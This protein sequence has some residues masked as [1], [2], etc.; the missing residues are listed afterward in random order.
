MA[1]T[2][3]EFLASRYFLTVYPSLTGAKILPFNV[4]EV[5]TTLTRYYSL[6]SQNPLSK[7]QRLQSAKVKSLQYSETKIYFHIF[8][9]SF[10]ATLRLGLW[11]KSQRII[12][13]YVS[14]LRPMPFNSST[15][16]RLTLMLVYLSSSLISTTHN[17]YALYCT[18]MFFH[19]NIVAS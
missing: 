16:E 11:A 8:L 2:F 1:D 9:S 12:S 17:Y 3:I 19:K 18:F 13:L 5:Q 14:P 10:L 15:V 6:T 4:S 7:Q